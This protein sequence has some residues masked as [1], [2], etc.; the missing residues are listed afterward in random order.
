MGA[1]G[2]LLLGCIACCAYCCGAPRRPAGWWCLLHF[3]IDPSSSLVF[4][5]TVV[6]RELIPAKGLSITNLTFFLYFEQFWCS[7]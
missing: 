3:G 6:W 2:V 7:R 5:V 1:G 4:F